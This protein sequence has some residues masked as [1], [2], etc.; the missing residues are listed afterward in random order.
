[1]DVQTLLAVCQQGLLPPRALGAGPGQPCAPAG[2]AGECCLLYLFSVLGRRGL[3]LGLG[4]CAP[5][6][7]WAF[8]FFLQPADHLEGVS[9]SD[10]G[11][12][13]GGVCLK[14]AASRLRQ[15]AFQTTPGSSA[16]SLGSNI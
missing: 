7:N 9:G 11:R 6:S 15:R 14:R 5:F 2:R 12:Q 16:G 4:M 3:I 8:F 13:E 10:Q 1:M